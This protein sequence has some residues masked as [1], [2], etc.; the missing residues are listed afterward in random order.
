VV[1]SK[2]KASYETVYRNLCWAQVCILLKS[3]YGNT[4]YSSKSKLHIRWMCFKP[5]TVKRLVSAAHA[6]SLQA[7]TLPG[8]DAGACEI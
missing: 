1:S 2:D 3:H 6:A 4:S 7:C 5:G 8:R